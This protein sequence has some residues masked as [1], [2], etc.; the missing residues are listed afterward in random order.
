MSDE[1]TYKGKWLFQR[2]MPL[3]A[4]RLGMVAESEAWRSLCRTTL[5]LYPVQGSEDGSHPIAGGDGMK[6]V[7]GTQIIWTVGAVLTQYPQAAE[8]WEALG[9][10]EDDIHWQYGREL[11][12]LVND[13]VPV[14]IASAAIARKAGRKAQGIYKAWLT[15]KQFT[16]AQREQYYLAPYSVF[17]HARMCDDPLAVLEYYVAENSKPG[18]CSVDEIEA[19]FPAGEEPPAPHDS[20]YPRYALGLWRNIQS[21]NGHRVEAEA[22]LNQI[23]QWIKESEKK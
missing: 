8:R 7:R 6:D 21:L 19:V 13:G 18:G 17:R 15:Y 9:Q 11:D 23:V 3:L 5:Y 10:T 16:D 14:G 22:M 20:Q 2:R 1:N 4:H 12:A